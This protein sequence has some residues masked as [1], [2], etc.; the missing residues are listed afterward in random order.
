M[1]GGAQRA[2][3]FL[4]GDEEQRKTLAGL[5]RRGSGTLSG[6]DGRMRALHR[7][8]G[9]AAS[10]AGNVGCHWRPPLAADAGLRLWQ[11]QGTRPV[12]I[13]S[14][15]EKHVHAGGA[16]SGRVPRVNSA[17][18]DKVKR[19]ARASRVHAR[20]RC[21]RSG[22]AAARWCP[23]DHRRPDPTQS[24]HSMF[25]SR[26]R[27]AVAADVLAATLGGSECTVS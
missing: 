12:D 6:A 16:E 11:V 19:L 3:R 5:L 13:K 18:K 20:K 25:S 23:H 4:W 7:A 14:G 27:E 1:R 26:L 21:N 15:A 9:A 2:A 24:R 22:M 17:A 8:F 10:N